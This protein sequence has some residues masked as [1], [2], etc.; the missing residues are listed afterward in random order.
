VIGTL[1]KALKQ[2]QHYWQE[3]YNVKYS[4]GVG[5]NAESELKTRQWE[6]NQVCVWSDKCSCFYTL[7]RF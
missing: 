6:K 1:L 2:W 4:F 5:V 7:E 3:H